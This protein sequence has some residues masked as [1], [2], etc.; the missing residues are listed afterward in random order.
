MHQKLIVILMLLLI[1]KGHCN[2]FSGKNQQSINK[3]TTLLSL[4]VLEKMNSIEVEQALEAPERAY[5]VNIR[6][7]NI[8]KLPLLKYTQ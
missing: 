7:N 1:F 2:N 8:D 6:S 3:D 4:S 5:K